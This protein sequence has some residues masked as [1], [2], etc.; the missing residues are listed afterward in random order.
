MRNMK[1][2]TL[3]Y[4]GIQ[5]NVVWKYLRIDVG[6]ADSLLTYHRYPW[7]IAKTHAPHKESDSAM[8]SA[9]HRADTT[10][11]LRGGSDSGQVHL[12]PTLP[13]S[14]SRVYY[15]NLF[16]VHGPSFA[17]LNSSA[18]PYP[19]EVAPGVAHEV[20]RFSHSN[21]SQGVLSYPYPSAR[22]SLFDH[23]SVSIKGYMYLKYPISKRQK[24]VLTH[25]S[26]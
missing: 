21:G 18:Q 4:L 12:R 20:A 8:R 17:S 23:Q 5:A 3:G 24:S 2:P 10:C 7:P 14:W 22:A 15:E 9:A 11:G 13:K 26:V 1:I 25:V 6:D 16:P 19:L